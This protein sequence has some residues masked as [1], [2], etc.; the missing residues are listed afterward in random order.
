ME[1]ENQEGRD[2][3]FVDY[4][5]KE[6]PNCSV[7]G[8]RKHVM[9][10]ISDAWKDLNRECLFSPPFFKLIAQA[11]LNIARMVPLMYA[12]DENGCLPKI[13]TYMKSLM[14]NPLD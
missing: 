11:S 14:L 4:Y 6:N 7:E 1:D 3:S 13:E 9:E 12:Y 10:M 8:A 5:I 2:G